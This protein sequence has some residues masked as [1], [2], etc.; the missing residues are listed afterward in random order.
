MLSKGVTLSVNKTNDF[1]ITSQ[2]IEEDLKNPNSL[3]YQD[4]YNARMNALARKQAIKKIEYQYIATQQLQRQLDELENKLAQQRELA[5]IQNRD[6]LERYYADQHML[7]VQN[8]GLPSNSQ[9]TSTDNL[10]ETYVK[11]L[12]ATEALLYSLKNQRED[13]LKNYAEK[14]KTYANAFITQ[15]NSQFNFDADRLPEEVKEIDRHVVERMSER[16][17]FDETLKMLGP[18]HIINT[19]I[20]ADKGRDLYEARR[21][22]N[23]SVLTSIIL[24]PTVKARLEIISIQIEKKCS[25]TTVNMTVNTTMLTVEAFNPDNQL[26]QNERETANALAARLF[27]QNKLQTGQAMDMNNDGLEVEARSSL[28]RGG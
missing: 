3:L 14:Q 10:V 24:R 1:Q 5:R 6:N 8:T 15:L 20:A 22:F 9:K 12:I 25:T 26:V 18:D 21:A 19:M 2:Q 11:Q 16:K 28:K 27:L 23:N 17:P 4:L 7:L 13:I